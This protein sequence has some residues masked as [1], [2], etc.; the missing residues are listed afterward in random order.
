MSSLS[1]FSF[2]RVHLAVHTALTEANVTATSVPGLSK[3]FNPESTFLKPFHGLETAYLQQQY[4][5]ANLGMIVS[6]ACV[7]NMFGTRDLKSQYNEK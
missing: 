6:G 4:C 2:C 7:Q 5:K 3:I 1:S